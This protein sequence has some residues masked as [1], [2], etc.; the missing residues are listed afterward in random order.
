MFQSRNNRRDCAPSRRSKS[1]GPPATNN[2]ARYI[3]AYN[4]LPS[5]E[6]P[7][8]FAAFDAAEYLV[9]PSCKF[10][11]ASSSYILN[12]VGSAVEINRRRFEVRFGAEL[13]FLSFLNALLKKKLI[14][15]GMKAF[16][17]TNQL[18]NRVMM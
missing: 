10:R 16:V 5:P 1:E 15:I 4:G 7:T 17:S 13:K 14:V 3:L 9:G 11:R 18:P 12:P 6:Q 2:Y 8:D